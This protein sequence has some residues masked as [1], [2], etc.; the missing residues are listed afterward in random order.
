[1]SA[2]PE[3]HNFAGSEPVLRY[4]FP[5]TPNSPSLGQWK[6]TFDYD[7]WTQCSKDGL[8]PYTLWEKVEGGVVRIPKLESTLH[9]IKAGTPHHIAGLFGYWRTSDSDIIWFRV[10]REGLVHEAM[11]LGGCPSAYEQD[12]ISWICPSCAKEFGKVSIKTG[13]KNLSRFW[14]EESVVLSNFNASESSRTCPKCSRLHPLA[15]EFKRPRDADD[16]PNPDLNW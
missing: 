10:V 16:N 4:I 11:V 15:Y 14:A 7:V 3:I 9:V 13:R 2:I 5:V 1:M 12:S 6:R 8:D